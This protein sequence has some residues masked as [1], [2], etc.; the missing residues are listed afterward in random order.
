MA[1][2][3][4]DLNTSRKN[5]YAAG[6]AKNLRIQWE[7]F[8]LFCIHFQLCYIPASTE[9]L[10]LYS[11]FLSRSFKSTSAIKNYISGVK[12]MHLL[13]GYSIDQI[14]GFLLN[15]SLKGIARLHPYCVKQAKAI[16]PD[17]LLEFSTML[18]FSSHTDSAFW[19]LF[20]FAF[21]LFARK[22]N[23]VPTTRQDLISKKCLLH[24]D[25]KVFSDF[26][27]VSFRWSKTIQFGE[28]VL[29]TPLVRIPGSVLCPVTAYHN[30]CKF[31]SFEDLDSLFTLPNK[32]CIF[33]R[34]FQAK[35]KFLIH[36]IGLNPEEFSS[37]SFRRGGCSFCFKSEVP[38]ELIQLH[39]DWRSDAYKKYLAFSL[40][41]KISVA[42][43]MKQQIL[44]H[45]S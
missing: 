7:S 2:L 42:E 38:S 20:L 31:G 22:S 36:K 44:M 5:A 3:K 26:L 11:Q 8:L 1:D 9:T 12:T 34:D 21:F 37:H 4:K 16:T 40:E 23:L 30:M 35:L 33:Y 43:K 41:D 32:K 24:K 13:L 27:I 29:E 6:T 15:L 39:G 25:L 17:I 19:C 10:C 45:S 28:R 18:N 14:N